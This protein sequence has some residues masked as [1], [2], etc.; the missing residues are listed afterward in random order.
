MKK[1][2]TVVLGMLFCTSAY[3]KVTPAPIFRDHMV[4]QRE[5][6]VPVWGTAD[7]GETV[8]VSFAGQ[9]AETTADAKGEW[10]VS[11][12]PLKTNATPQ[13]LTI[14][15]IA[16]KDV[17]VGEVWLCSGQ[18]NME[19]K[20]YRTIGADKVCAERGANPLIR[21]ARMEPYR[22]ERLPRRDF[23]ISWQ[24]LTPE[25]AKTFSAVA[26]YFGLS[27]QEK[28]GIPIGLISSSWGGTRIE[29]WTP[30]CGFDGIPELKKIAYSV[31]AKL[32]WRPE[33]RENAE[34]TIAAYQSWLDQFRDAAAKGVELP[35]PPAYPEV[36]KPADR[37]QAPTV[38]YNAMIYPFV[39]F[40]F[41]GVIWYQ[42]CSNRGDDKYLPKM[43]AL[44]DGWKKVFRN[45]AMKFYF[46]QL[47]PFRYGGDVEALPRIWEAQSAFEK[48]NEPQVGMAVINDL[49]EYGD[50]HPRNKAPVG[51]RLAAF[52]L[53]RDYGVRGIRPECPRHT[54]FRREGKS[55]VISFEHVRAWKTASGGDV[56]GFQ[57]AG[58]DGLFRNAQAVVRGTDIVL[59]HPEIALPHA[60]RYLWHETV[61]GKLFNENGL[62][63]TAFRVEEPID[64]QALVEELAGEGWQLAYDL[65]L[66][67]GVT[68]DVA[69]YGIDNSRKLTGKV[70][71][72]AYLVRGKRKNGG[73]LWL[74]T[75]MDAF[76]P[77]VA[78]C[79]V[80]C[81]GTQIDFQ[82]KVKNISVATN[83]PGIPCGFFPEGNIEFWPN[84][85]GVSPG[86]KLPGANSRKYDFDDVKA[87]K[88]VD[89]YGC[90][91]IHLFTHKTTLFAFNNFN[92]AHSGADFGIGNNPAPGGHP[93]WTLARNLAKDWS[94][95]SIR[96]YVMME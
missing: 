37:N 10:M 16:I 73:D 25:S 9:T 13:M 8:R 64:A 92:T 32:P 53:A 19:M 94:S 93:D 5:M 31:N 63:L 49:G 91:Q 52:A 78:K 96:I 30:P 65:D 51:E 28:L 84:N 20:M 89:G 40:A 77:D 68:E 71:R 80:P 76:T 35:P 36:L 42:G 47:A 86:L 38:I 69:Q 39:P 41:R 6:A 17:L 87:V 81:F 22:W 61:T 54:G 55:L 95:A 67:K 62:P 88:P 18:S 34:K 85:Y 79:G 1:F 58:V 83:C 12:Q 74:L 48:A 7:A 60:A 11:L 82:Q 75:A 44:F 45:P 14:N 21:T 29:P 90:M 56:E 66:F 27:L 70:K 46:V 26:L 23:P 72:V 59:T 15:D 50:I 33:F 3:A 57:L 2:L 24:P 43:Q 4:L